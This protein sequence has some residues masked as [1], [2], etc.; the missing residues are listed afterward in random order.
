MKKLKCI[1]YLY[2]F[3]YSGIRLGEVS[4][5]S[6]ETNLWEN[7]LFLYCRYLLFFSCV[8]KNDIEINGDLL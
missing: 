2:V 7:V 1:Q 4:K 3:V 8:I 6:F 5:G